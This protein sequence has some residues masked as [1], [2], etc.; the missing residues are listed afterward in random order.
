MFEVIQNI[1]KQK[2]I[3]VYQIK[4]KKRSCQKNLMLTLR[5]HF[6]PD[7]CMVS[8]ARDTLIK[9][10]QLNKHLQKKKNCEVFSMIW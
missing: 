9:N 10:K 6:V 8:L 2:R 1:M 3:Y 4:K 7:K 5:K